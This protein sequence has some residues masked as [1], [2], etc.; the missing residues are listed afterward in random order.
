MLPFLSLVPPS[1]ALNLSHRPW[2][3]QL[4]SMVDRLLVLLERILLILNCPALFES[5]SFL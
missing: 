3:W 5:C 1:D 2:S 4:V